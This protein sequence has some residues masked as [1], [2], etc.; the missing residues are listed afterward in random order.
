MRPLRLLCVFLVTLLLAACQT[1]NPELTND[2]EAQTSSGGYGSTHL[3]ARFLP[4]IAK[5]DPTGAFERGLQIEVRIFDLDLRKRQAYGSA[6]GPNYATGGGISTHGD[7]YQLNWN[8]STTHRHARTEYVRLE[9]R[10]AGAPA[11]PACNDDGPYCLGYLDVRLVPNMGKGA[12]GTPAG[13]MNVVKTST[14]PVKFVVLALETVPPPDT[15]GE[16]ESLGGGNFDESMGNCVASELA[17]PGQGLQ[18][19][20]A[21]LQAIGAGLQAVGAV[22]GLFSGPTSSFS[23]DLAS[24]TT[25]PAT[26]ASRLVAELGRSA[27]KHGVVL[28]VVDDFGGVF[29]VPASLLSGRG[30]LL[31]LAASGALSHGAV[32]LHHLKQLAVQ[33]F[34]RL[35]HQGVNATTGQPYFKY[36]TGSGP[37]LAIQVV[38]VAGLNTDDVPGAIRA[39]MQFMGGQGPV[40]YQ[41]VV[42][43]MSFTVVPCTVLSDFGTSGLPNF[44]SY[45]EAIRVANNIGSQYLSELDGL[46]STPVALAREALFAYLECPF[47]VA[48]GARCDGRPSGKHAR[49]V[50]DSIVHVGASGNYG[51]D[52]SLYPAA[53]PNVVSVG[54]LDVA[55]RS[56][57]PAR[58][59]YSNAAGVLAPGG[60]FLLSDARGQTTVYAGTSFA[61]PVVS[62]FVALDQMKQEPRCAAGRLGGSAATTPALALSDS[63]QLPLLSAFSRSGQNALSDVCS[64]RR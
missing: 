19:V 64:P 46:V 54:S 42:V 12:K 8:A 17:R 39:A 34:G 48:G 53:W 52:Y 14:L 15:L 3:R 63:T 47:P 18:A 13:I 1:V 10:L 2:L 16:L 44:E 6:L 57:S 7:R 25:T 59:T 11:G 29:D 30:D 56:F 31:E 9:I 58:S 26:V 28:L 22:G 27:D 40:G 20:G 49:A 61:A 43:N 21:G 23:S 38:D 55:G 51:N 60:L 41:R 62:L 5:K 24:R 45:L 36:R 35:S 33:A 4:P 50:A 37:Y 32:V